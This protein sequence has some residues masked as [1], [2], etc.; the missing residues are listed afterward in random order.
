MFIQTNKLLYTVMP[1]IAGLFLFFVRHS[2]L[3]ITSKIGDIFKIFIHN[4][5]FKI[6]GFEANYKDG[7]F[8]LYWTLSWLVCRFTLIQP[9]YNTLVATGNSLEIQIMVQLVSIVLAMIVALIPA[10]LLTCYQLVNNYVSVFHYMSCTSDLWYIRL[11]LRIHVI[12]S[13]IYYSNIRLCIAFVSIFCLFVGYLTTGNKVFLAFFLLIMYARLYCEYFTLRVMP[14]MDRLSS[15]FITLPVDYFLANLRYRYWDNRLPILLGG[16]TYEE[17]P[18]YHFRVITKEN[19]DSLE[20]YYKQILFVEF[21]TNSSISPD[22]RLEVYNKVIIGQGEEEDIFLRKIKEDLKNSPKKKKLKGNT[23]KTHKRSFHTYSASNL[24]FGDLPDPYDGKTF[25]S[26]NLEEAQKNAFFAKVY[27]EDFQ[28]VSKPG[29]GVLESSDGSSLGRSWEEDLTG[30]PIPKSAPLTA[31]EEARIREFINSQHEKPSEPISGKP[32]ETDPLVKAQ[33][34]NLESEAAFSDA[35][36]QELLDTMKQ[37]SQIA[38]W[39]HWE[40]RIAVSRQALALALATGG[41]VYAGIMAAD[42]M[43]QMAQKEGSLLHAAA[44]QIQGIGKT[45]GK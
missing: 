27:K 35:K 39:N 37:K 5:L 43:H 30:T 11:I 25:K 31:N 12:R 15:P 24:P 17:W 21:T 44:Q 13:S 34:K 16:I 33:I 7:F 2:L 41:G 45:S 20:N 28:L 18:D 36:T 38:R 10:I 40:K 6:P 1:V 8:I 9:I 42:T 29:S 14:E 3:K 4:Y 22:K 32:S 26:F 23:K 19:F